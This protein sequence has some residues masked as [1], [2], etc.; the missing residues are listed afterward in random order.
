MSPFE[1]RSDAHLWKLVHAERAVLAD[2]LSSLTEAQW[3]TTS[4]CS[5]FTVRKVVA[6]LTAAAS[7][8]SLRWM[9]GVIRCR[10]DFD[11]QVTMRMTE[12]LGDSGADTL[13]RFRAVINSTTSPPL[14]V[15]A[16]LGEAVVHGED[17][18]RP[19]GIERTYP[20]TTLTKLAE[21]Y[22]GSDMMVPAKERTTGLQLVA[23]DGPFVTGSGPVVTGP[24]LALIMAMTG[25][26]VFFEELE[27][28]GVATLR[29]RSVG[30]SSPD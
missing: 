13:N 26:M 7:L 17:I 6:H 4:L 23:T 2:D 5:E 15:V 27:G 11:K 28:D 12:H 25:R 19:L 30:E 29:N 18:R 22:Q 10:F 3:A 21:C 16:M 14:P 24:T 20:I 1:R 8:N 9:A